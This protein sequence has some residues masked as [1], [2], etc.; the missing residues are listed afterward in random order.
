[1]LEKSVMAGKENLSP[2]Q[3]FPFL[4]ALL[5][6]RNTQR[7]ATWPGLPAPRAEEPKCLQTSNS[8]FSIWQKSPGMCQHCTT[9][10]PTKVEGP[11][12]D[13][14]WFLRCF[15]EF[16]G[17]LHTQGR[18]FGCPLQVCFFKR[19]TLKMLSLMAFPASWTV[20][21][22]KRKGQK[23]E[24]GKKRGRGGERG[25][26]EAKKEENNFLSM[27][28]RFLIYQLV[29]RYRTWTFLEEKDII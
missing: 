19:K 11:H 12:P 5:C 10:L 3:E 2:H 26:K 27:L 4:N 14:D 24:G 7:K 22:D 17:Y 23:G 20:L 8:L 9:A 6:P 21:I 28:P 1:M 16:W 13:T 29:H 25:K 18:T 15:A